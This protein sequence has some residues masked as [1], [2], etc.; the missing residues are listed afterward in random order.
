M[1]LPCRLEGLLDADVELMA[2]VEREPDAA[3]RA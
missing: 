3:S 1:R 2:A